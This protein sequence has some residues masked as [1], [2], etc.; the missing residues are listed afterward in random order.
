[1]VDI[2]DKKAG[3]TPAWR[4]LAVL[5][6]LGVMS[7]TLVADRGVPRFD[8]HIPETHYLL[9]TGGGRILLNGGGALLCQSC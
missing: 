5:A 2:A 9:L 8:A 6:W 4:T 3:V 7:F 1:M